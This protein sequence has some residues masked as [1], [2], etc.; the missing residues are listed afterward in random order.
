MKE[1]FVPYALAIQLKEKGFQEPCL[2]YYQVSKLFSE[3]YKLNYIQYEE[4]NPLINNMLS[5]D[6]SAPLYQQVIDWF[7]ENYEIYISSF[8]QFQNKIEDECEEEIIYI[9][10]LMSLTKTRKEELSYHPYVED[11]NYFENSK[12]QSYYGSLNEVIEE[13]LRL[14]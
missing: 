4:D 9:Y 10:E 3:G 7:R 8:I 2:A 11:S 13:A 1:L 6:I 14:I 5:K 12:D